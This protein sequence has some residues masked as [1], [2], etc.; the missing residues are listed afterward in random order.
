MRRMMDMEKKEELIEALS[1][2]MLDEDLE[3]VK[4]Q[5]EEKEEIKHIT[6]EERLEWMHKS[7]KAKQDQVPESP[8]DWFIFRNKTN[9]QEIRWTRDQVM[10]E[11]CI[12]IPGPE[13]ELINIIKL[14]IGEAEKSAK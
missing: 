8:G 9:N 13:F 1:P 12:N 7:W 5:L 10:G 14:Q 4:E 2:V 3:K 11:D 6:Q